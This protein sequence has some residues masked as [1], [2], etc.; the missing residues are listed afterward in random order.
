[1]TRRS[2]HVLAAIVAALGAAATA[3]FFSASSP[4]AYGAT[5]PA[6][7]IVRGPYLQGT[8]A[9]GTLVLWQTEGSAAEG[10]SLDGGTPEPG[11]SGSSHQVSFGG[12]AALTTHTYSI[13]D[14]T[15]GGVL[16]GPIPF[17]TAPANGA[18]TPFTI[19]AMGD[20]GDGT[21]AQEDLAAEIAGETFDLVLHAGD[22]VYPSGGIADYLQH[23]FVP[24]ASVIANHCVFPTLGNHDL[25]EATAPGY[26]NTF[27]IPTNGPDSTRHDYAFTWGC[28]HV[29][30]LD[31]WTI[32]K[33][34]PSPA[35]IS[36]LESELSAST[37]TWQVVLMHVPAFSSGSEYAQAKPVKQWFVPIFETYHVDLVLVGHDHAYERLVPIQITTGSGARPVQY[38]L[39]GGA[40]GRPSTIKTTLPETV[41][42]K[43]VTHFLLL[44]VTTTQIHGR[45]LGLEGTVIDDFTLS[46]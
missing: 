16:A 2:S 19:L 3:R 44:D 4:T 14:T 27:V 12:L 46:K 5:P 40:G 25:D 8:S 42:R 1:M 17:R 9:T 37:S 45:A 23:Y 10:A 31:D 28:M 26:F 38:V 20:S 13:V 22:V 21:D 18:A 7:T 6:S 30:V 33:T 32:Q 43:E 11:G 35:F 15:S 29:V 39:T 34:P 24:Y 36:W 41:V